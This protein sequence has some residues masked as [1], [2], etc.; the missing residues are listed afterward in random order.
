MTRRISALRSRQQIGQPLL[1]TGK[2]G[3]AVTAIGDT[4][5]EGARHFGQVC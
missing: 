2:S 4:E 1:R 5:N 3:G